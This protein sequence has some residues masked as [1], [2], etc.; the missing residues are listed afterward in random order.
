[1]INMGIRNNLFM[2]K[3]FNSNFVYSENFQYS[4]KNL[5][6]SVDFHMI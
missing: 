5:S 2:K 3:F 4:L 6:K 1:M